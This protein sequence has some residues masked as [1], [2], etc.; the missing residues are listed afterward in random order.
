VHP[1][2][3]RP[4]GLRGVL[5]GMREMREGKVSGVKLVYKVAETS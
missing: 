2:S 5:D 4:D 1:P 3:V